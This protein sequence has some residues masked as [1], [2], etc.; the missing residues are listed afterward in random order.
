MVV[1]CGGYPSLLNH[2][3]MSILHPALLAG[4]G[5][6]L[7]PVLLHL[8]LRAKPKRLVFPALR[9]IRQNRRQNVRRMQL[10]HLWLLLLRILVIVLIVTA[11]SRPSLPAA[12]Y[13]L[14]WYEW[15]LLVLIIGICA[16]AY[17]GILS[18]WKKQSWPR[19]QLLTRRSMLRGSV[20]VTTV[21]LLM[22]GVGL[23]YIRRVSAEIKSP[24]PHMAENVP[25]A[26]VFLFDISPSMSY[27]EGNQ[28]RLQQAQQIARDHLSRL[29]GGSK[30]AVTGTHEATAAGAAEAAMPAFS[31]DLQ[32]ARNRIDALDIRPASPALN[33][34]LR[35]A[36][37]GQEDDR[38]RVTAEQ[39]VPEEK[40]QDRYLREI[41]I[42]TDLAKTAWRED[43][44][45]VLREDLK[46]LN[47]VSI[48]LI[49][50]GESSPVNAA[51]TGV[52]LS[53]E[54][55]PAG[56]TIKVEATLATMGNMKP[57]Q[58]IELFLSG[59][60]GKLVKKGQQS[61]MLGAGAE[62]KVQFDA[63]GITGRYRQGEIRIAGS[64][65]MPI[66]DVGYFTVQTLPPLRILIVS[67]SPAIARY[68]QSALDYISNDKITDF[69][70]KFLPSG[71]LE[72]TDLTTFDVVCLINVAAPDDPAWQKL[73]DFVE[74]GG[75]LGVFLGASSSAAS[76]RPRNDQIN[77]VAYNTKAAQSVLP[78]EL[79]AS[80]PHSP[81][82]TLDLRGTQHV[83]LKRLEEWNSLAELGAVDIRRYWKVEPQ[84]SSL[85]VARY[86]SSRAAPAIVERRLG[87]GRVILMTTG[88]DNVEWN[89][90]VG[91]PWYF[92]FADQLMQYLSQQASLRC[93]HTVGNEVI[94]PLDRENKL[95]KVVIRM[96]DFKQQPSEVM[97]GAK[98]LFLK[99][100][101]TIGSYRVD[102]ADGDVN[103]HHGFSLNL[104]PQESDLRK[105]DS[106]ELDSLLGE[107]RYLLTRD[108]VNLQK[109]VDTTRLGQEV[110][111]L[112]VAVLIG[113][114]AAEQFTAAW[115]YRTDEA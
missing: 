69:Q 21:A 44:S 115:F 43:T 16:A 94:L 113:V 98:S 22:L 74:G 27:R 65:P 79:I 109:I 111:S 78:A 57:E 90:L 19:N 101:T 64:D 30:V 87:Q 85:V 77:P 36:L 81:A 9:L 6:A 2:S 75:G 41:Y 23:P 106:H 100:L 110:Y 107:K 4:L 54:T 10:R 31:L 37:R 48:Y 25:V 12:N 1:A 15:L 51:V 60:D 99:D 105:L 24:L 59:D 13:G 71:R 39:N 114:F 83:L 53:R 84:Q 93:N 102:S 40:R 28:T 7:I 33:E 11:L 91:T 52:R 92:V 89:D 112:I 42:F 32:A 70:T 82:Q 63:A 66:D 3:Q 8:L 62:Q 58:T 72:A 96:P 5:L 17:I 67:E 68:W 20:G 14:V 56:G 35:T 108:L 97:A 50:V 45:N 95:K 49:D 18:W 86:S 38:R 76:N 46:R 55:V 29:P 34:R 104:A 73:H 47:F 80:L 61:V 26:A 88:V 103:F